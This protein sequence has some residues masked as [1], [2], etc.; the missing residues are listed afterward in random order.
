[1][2]T[3]SNLALL[4]A[5]LLGCW[6]V[7]Q[8][9][10]TFGDWGMAGAVEEGWAGAGVGRLD[11]DRR[12]R[13]SVG[14]L[15]RKGEEKGNLAM[16]RD[17]V[18]VE[19]REFGQISILVQLVD[20]GR[21]QISDEA[22]WQRTRYGFYEQLHFGCWIVSTSCIYKMLL[23]KNKTKS[24]NHLDHQKSWNHHHHL[25]GPSHQF[26]TNHAQEPNITRS[27][28]VVKAALSDLPHTSHTLR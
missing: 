8:V 4:T 27:S 24:H 1:M 5:S 23:V 16:S 15:V 11:A 13:Y 10:G 22:L 6:D 2:A 7:D 12:E 20:D 18:D 17:M 21:N 19:R 25:P 3:C 9:V 28:L 26:K 14:M